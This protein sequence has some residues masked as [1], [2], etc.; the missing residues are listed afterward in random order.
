[1]FLDATYLVVRDNYY[2]WRSVIELVS[3]GDSFPTVNYGA[4]YVME[5]GKW[6]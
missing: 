1:M 3:L 5:T 6:D 2:K 4:G